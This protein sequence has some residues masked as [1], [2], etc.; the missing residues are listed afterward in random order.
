MLLGVGFG[1]LGGIITAFSPMFFTAYS[2]SII[3]I[4][5]ASGVLFVPDALPQQATYWL[6][7]NPALQCVEWMRAAYYEGY[8][9]QI[10]DKTYTVRWGIVTVL[11]GLALE[12]VVRGKVLSTS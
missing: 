5:V 8:G 4:W 3:V 1:I 10:L 11:L 12:R 9:S 7:Y 2:I 6:S